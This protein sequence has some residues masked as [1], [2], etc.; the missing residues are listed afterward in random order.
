MDRRKYH[1][2]RRAQL[3]RL[4]ALKSDIELHVSKERDGSIS[5]Y[6]EPGRLTMHVARFCEYGHKLIVHGKSAGSVPA[7]SFIR[8][9]VESSESTA[10]AAIEETIAEEINKAA[11]VQGAR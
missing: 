9:S 3:H 1:G 5:A 8:N 10:L 6:V 4:G 11:A 7:H 2:R